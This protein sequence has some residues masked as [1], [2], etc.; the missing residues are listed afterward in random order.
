MSYLHG[1]TLPQHMQ[2]RGA[3]SPPAPR[4]LEHCSRMFP[5]ETHPGS[6]RWRGL[7]KPRWL[8]ALV[9]GPPWPDVE[10]DDDWMW[11]ALLPRETPALT[12]KGGSCLVRP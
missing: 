1:A 8:C 9:L 3:P 10:E 12:R 6:G 2:P 7:P 11:K 4:S 5:V